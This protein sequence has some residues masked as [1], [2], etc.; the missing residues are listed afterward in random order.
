MTVATTITAI[1]EIVQD[2]P[3]EAPISG[4]YTAGGTSLTIATYYTGLVEGDILDFAYDGTYEQFRVIPTPSSSTVAVKIAHNGTTNANHASGAY[5][6]KNPRFGT[7]QIVNAITHI[8]GTRLWPDLWVPTTTTITPNPTVTN[9]YDLPSDYESFIS[10]VQTATGT[11]EDIVY[12]NTV[13][14]LLDVPTGISSTLK[15]LRITGWPRDDV[16]ATL[17][18][19]AKPTTTNMTSA[20]EPVIA[21]GVA[22]YLLRTEAGEKADRFDEDDRPGRMLRSAQALERQFQF[23]KQQ[24]RAQLLQ[25]WGPVRR[26]RH[27]RRV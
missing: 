3:W 6:V 24:V 19:R 1:R 4:A 10:L 11:I 17:T 8:V 26:F 13:Q 22:A 9:I 2:E 23:E 5:F 15:A 7:Q 20:M 18:Y 27:G 25:Q 12:V 21:L 14:E 16:N